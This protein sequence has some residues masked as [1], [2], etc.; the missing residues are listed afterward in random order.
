MGLFH[1][2]KVKR[3][4]Q[5]SVSSSVSFNQRHGRFCSLATA[6]AEDDNYW[7]DR[8]TR[9]FRL[10]S[11]NFKEKLRCVNSLI[12]FFSFNK[13]ECPLFLNYFCPGMSISIFPPSSR[14]YDYHYLLRLYDCYHHDYYY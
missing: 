13:I 14:D 1:S 2:V 3:F 9:A 6:V 8:V 7:G 4:K 10:R 5:E 11:K 12:L